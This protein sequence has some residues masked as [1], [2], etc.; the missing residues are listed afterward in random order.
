VQVINKCLA[1]FLYCHPLDII[2]C[3]FQ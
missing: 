1:I 2:V 3:T